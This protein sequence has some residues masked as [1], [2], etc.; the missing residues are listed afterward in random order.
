MRPA[1]VRNT[2]RTTPRR[3]RRA[4]PP[5]RSAIS[6]LRPDKNRLS[7]FAFPTRFRSRSP[8]RLL[9]VRSRAAAAR[10][11]EVNTDRSARPAMR[12]S[13]ASWGHAPP[14]GRPVARRR[15]PW[16]RRR[17]LV[18]SHSSI[19]ARAICSLQE[20]HPANGEAWRGVGRRRRRPRSAAKSIAYELYLRGNEMARTSTMTQERACT[21]ACIELDRI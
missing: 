3:S 18:A 19:V 21:N 15:T 1:R 16:T 11:K 4:D 20:H 7:P 5:G 17:T 6:V 8:H 10:F 13:T 2:R 12:T 9:V 14:I